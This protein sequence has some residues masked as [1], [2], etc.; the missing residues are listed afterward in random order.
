ALEQAV[1]RLVRVPA[2]LT[3]CRA[4]HDAA[5]PWGVACGT[6]RRW[7]SHG[8]KGYMVRLSFVGGRLRSRGEDNCLGAQSGRPGGPGG[9]RATAGDA[10]PP[11][12]LSNRAVHFSPQGGFGI[13]GSRKGGS[14]HAA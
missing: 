14:G 10:G 4:A 1:M 11:A 5:P 3:G 7:R 13:P 12:V 2:V 9:C 6:T 8:E